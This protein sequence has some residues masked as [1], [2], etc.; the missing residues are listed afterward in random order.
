LIDRYGG[1][2]RKAITLES[3]PELRPSP[4]PF[5]PRAR[6]KALGFVGRWGVY[7]LIGLVFFVIVTEVSSHGH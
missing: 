2:G 4:R 7:F 1:L 6:S 5:R 3:R